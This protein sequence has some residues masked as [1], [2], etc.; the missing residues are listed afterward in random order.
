MFPSKFLL[1]FINLKSSFFILKFLLFSFKEKLFKITKKKKKK[2]KIKTILYFDEEASQS[3]RSSC[4]ARQT[5]NDLFGISD[6][7]SLFEGGSDHSS[8]GADKDSKAKGEGIGDD[9]DV[10]FVNEE[11]IHRED[12]GINLELV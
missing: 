1:I 3:R 5:L 4:D 12:H 8:F 2:W 6:N 11:D 9:V 10:E 7:D